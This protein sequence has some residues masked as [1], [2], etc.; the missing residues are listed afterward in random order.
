TEGHWWSDRVD[1]PNEIL[2]RERLGGIALR[3]NQT[4][5]GN[6]VSWRFDQPE[7]A[8]QVAILVPNPRPDAFRVIAYNTTSQPQRATMT[9]WTVTGGT[10][11][12]KAATSSDGGT[13][14][15]P[16]DTRQ[17]TLER[18]ASTEVTFAPGTTT[19][20]DFTLSQASSPVEQRSDLGI[21]IDDVTVQGRRVSVT[22]HSLGSQPVVGGAVTLVD[23]TGREVAHAA[24][25]ALAAPTD[26][27]PKTAT[28]RLS[29][30]GGVDPATLSV[31]VALPGDA[32]E[33][34]RQNNQVPLAELVRR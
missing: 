8:T 12:M 22:V 21:G 17:L 3:R 32:P 25:P 19:V 5:P 28:V 34:T 33:V 16:I 4:W 11:T 29:I 1:Q 9:G 15:T 31:R 27:S 2:Q 20:L 23:A 10:W 30:P 6:T 7:A 26:L 13:T 24:V 18:S 14:L